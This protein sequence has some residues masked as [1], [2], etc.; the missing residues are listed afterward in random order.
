MADI[1]LLTKHSKAAAVADALDLAGYRVVTI[2][3]FDTDTLGTFTGEIAR[4]GT[5]LDA[6]FAKAK[7]ATELSGGRFGLGSEGSFGPDPYLGMTGWGIEVL[8]WWDAETQFGVHAV[9]QGPETNYA[10]LSAPDLSSALAFATRVSFPTHGVIVG[11]PGDPWF[12]KELGSI[13]VL[14]QSI[15]TALAAGPVWLE[16]DMRAHRNPTRMAMIRRCAEALYTRLTHACPKCFRP[17]FGPVALIPGARCEL[18]GEPTRAARAQKLACGG[19]GFTAEELLR[20]HV[21]PANCDHCN[22]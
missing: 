16:T 13:A 4:K 3:D 22:P 15:V 12:A 6:A 10:Q 21:P 9:V 17:G 2:D 7:K 8:A 1:F 5:Q 20:E 19:C 11:K 18:C 14:E